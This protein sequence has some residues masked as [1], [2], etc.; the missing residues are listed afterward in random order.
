MVDYYFRFEVAAALIVF[1]V[2]IT[3]FK[4]NKIKTKVSS[5]FTAL[6]WQCFTASVLDIAAIFLLKYISKSNLW[7]CYIVNILYYFMFNAIPLCFYICLY[8]LSERYKVMPKRRYWAFFGTYLF[9]TL[10]LCT[11]PFTHCVFWFDSDLN[12]HYGF[13]FYVYYV[14]AAFY[15]G[16]GLLH[17]YRHKNLYSTNQVVLL[18]TFMAL[19]VISTIIQ[20]IY[21]QLVI[22]GFMLSMTI[23]I[24]YLS[25]E[26]PDDYMDSQM[27]IYNRRAFIVKAQENFDTNQK[28]FVVG[29]GS[30]NLVHILRSIGESNRKEFFKT[31]V[32]FLSEVFGKTNLFRLSLESIGVI[33]TEGTMEEYNEKLKLV[34]NFFMQPV[35]CGNFQVSV[36]INM[37]YAQAPEDVNTIED[38]IDL[39]EDSLADRSDYTSDKP[40]HAQIQLL[41]NRRREHKIVQLLEQAV[42]ENAFEI[43]YQPIYSVEKATYNCV[44]ALVRYKTEEFGYINPDEFLPLAEK[45][46]L[47]LKIGSFVFREVCKFIAENKLEQ[48]G[49]EEVH[50]NLSVIQCMQEKLYE[51]IFDIMDHY[52][53]DYSYINLNVTETTTIIANEILL[54]NMNTMLSHNMHYSLDNYGTGLSNTNT[55]VKFPFQKVKLDKTLIR[56][57]VNDSK[58]RIILQKT[59]SMVKDLGMQVVAEGVEG[60]GEYDMVIYLGCDFIQGFMFSEPLT[61]EEYLKFISKI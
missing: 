38:L 34:S 29:L 7:L 15:V 36:T 16:A 9:V 48:K 55:L 53:I 8:Y 21:P 10:L 61:P 25:L 47:M 54:R 40:C 23:L 50:I 14:L 51:H 39:L 27:G 22:T 32:E 3:F 46:G 44:E 56:S 4:L 18:G 35:K 49:I 24:T 28:M 37:K 2:I 26:N 30:E 12:F 5:A 13:V 20:I 43:V 42:N 58:A 45:N 1:A 19:C 41:E 31:L 6:I 33:L 52:D 59:V 60:Y 57:S 11:T 17:F